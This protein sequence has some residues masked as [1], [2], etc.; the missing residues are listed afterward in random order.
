MVVSKSHSSPSFV[1]FGCFHFAPQKNK[2]GLWLE[3][4]DWKLRLNILLL[5][6]LHS[7]PQPQIPEEDYNSEDYPAGADGPDPDED[8]APIRPPASHREYNLSHISRAIIPRASLD[9]S[10]PAGWNLNVEPD[11]TWV[12]SNEY[13]LEQV[14]FDRSWNAASHSWRRGTAPLPQIGGSPYQVF[15][16]FR[17]SGSSPWTTWA[18]LTIT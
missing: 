16:V 18:R 12:F 15:V 14:S 8:P 4:M 9:R 1:E 6:P 13:S 5:T 2:T 11:G 3:V 17:H 10:T 7:N